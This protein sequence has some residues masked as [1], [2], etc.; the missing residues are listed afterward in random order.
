MVNIY[1]YLTY[2]Q[3]SDIIDFNFAIGSNTISYIEDQNYKYSS[4]FS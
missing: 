4:L 1:P 3:N 2:Q